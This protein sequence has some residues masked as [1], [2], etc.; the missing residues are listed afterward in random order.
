MHLY[1]LLSCWKSQNT[2]EN[3]DLAS[4]D[5][6]KATPTDDGDY[7]TTIRRIFC[8]MEKL[9]TYLYQRNFTTQAESIRSDAKIRV[10]P[11]SIQRRK[12]KISQENIDP[13]IMAR[14]KRE[15][16]KKKMHKLSKSIVENKQN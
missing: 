6:H 1:V 8:Q 15:S 3:V 4:E 12:R 11:A 9:S 14:V 5:I 7:C 13:T 10:Q 16:S 2:K